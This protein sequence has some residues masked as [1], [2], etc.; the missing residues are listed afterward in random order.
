MFTNGSMPTLDAWKNWVRGKQK[1]KT[2]RRLSTDM[3][4]EI[5]SDDEVIAYAPY[6]GATHV[7]ARFTREHV[8]LHNPRG[9]PRARVRDR[10]RFFAEPYGFPV[11][12]VTHWPNRQALGLFKESPWRLKTP[13]FEYPDANVPNRATLLN[14]YYRN[15]RKAQLEAEM[16][17]VVAI[18]NG[19]FVRLTYDCT[20]LTKDASPSEDQI[21]RRIANFERR[22]E[23]GASRDSV[24]IELGFYGWSD[25]YGYRV[26]CW[27]ADEVKKMN[28]VAV[29]L[30]FR[31][32]ADA[33]VNSV[34]ITSPDMDEF[35]LELI[36]EGMGPMM[37]DAATSEGMGH[38]EDM[39]SPWGP[40]TIRKWYTS[41]KDGKRR[42]VGVRGTTY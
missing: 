11:V 38:F 10:L 28:D 41:P 2:T 23:E 16:N 39:P 24:A 30:G 15:K 42:M 19:G 37:A 7:F 13:E 25:T 27:D 21:A 29:K 26:K 4:V 9:C 36:D 32:V 1:N 14:E 12:T 22:S 33:W 20:V 35:D 18:R 34:P 3:K 5:V 40:G 8:E 31:H 17:H 6:R